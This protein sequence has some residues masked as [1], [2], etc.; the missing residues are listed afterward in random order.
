[1]VGLFVILI[2][3]SIVNYL[4]S[5]LHFLRNRI[6]YYVFG[7][8]SVPLFHLGDLWT[9]LTHLGSGA[10]D[11]GVGKGGEQVG[12]RAVKVVMATAGTVT[13]LVDRTA[14]VVATGKLEL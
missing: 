3:I 14:N 2:Y 7:D 10:V 1:M 11:G 12:T 8:E 9:S 4:P 13:S 5:Y 6:A